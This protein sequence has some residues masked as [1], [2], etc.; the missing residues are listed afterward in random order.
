MLYGSIDLLAYYGYFNI[1]IFSYVT[2]SEVILYFMKD[3]SYVV[4]SIVAMGTFFAILFSN[5]NER[6]ESS[7]LVVDKLME[8]VMRI[9]IY[10]GISVV[11]FLLVLVLIFF[12]NRVFGILVTI[13]SIFAF[14]LYFHQRD[15][16]VITIVFTGLLMLS[17]DYVN[18]QIRAKGA[19]ALAYGAEI[20]LQGKE[21]IKSD[22]VNYL[23]GKTENFIFIHRSKEQKTIVFPIS[24]LEY[25]SLPSNVSED[26]KTHQ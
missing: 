8:R 10:L 11:A 24:G 16:R 9:R 25:L 5:E 7:R 22:S 4:I 6:I 12:I 20:K 15:L 13:S 3:L 14:A 2:I 19:W 26:L 17:V 23:V 1:Q 18:A 21:P